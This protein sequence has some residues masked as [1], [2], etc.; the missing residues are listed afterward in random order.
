MASLTGFFTQQI[1]VFED[2]LMRDTSTR[3][4]VWRTNNYSATGMIIPGIANVTVKPYDPMIVAI[5]MGKCLSN[6]ETYIICSSRATRYHIETRNGKDSS[7]G[8]S[9]CFATRGDEGLNMRCAAEVATAL[10]VL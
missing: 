4:G 10:I 5:N 3:A 1:V 9:S 7:L 2:C 6:N 8:C